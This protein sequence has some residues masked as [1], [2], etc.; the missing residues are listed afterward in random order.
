M[1]NEAW[2]NELSDDQ[3]RIRVERI[4]REAEERKACRAHHRRE[5]Q[6]WRKKRLVDALM[7]LEDRELDLRNKNFELTR[8][9]ART[10]PSGTMLL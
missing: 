8:R 5:L 1:V 2:W 3:L 7:R 9:W 6:R 10:E 4:V